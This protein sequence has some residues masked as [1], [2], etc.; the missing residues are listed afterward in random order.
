[1][2]G[3]VEV[4]RWAEEAEEAGMDVGIA[5]CLA[6]AVGLTGALRD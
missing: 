6:A 2:L 5:C 1:M 3:R 4:A